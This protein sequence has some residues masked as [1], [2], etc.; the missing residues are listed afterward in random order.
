MFY[1]LPQAQLLNPV[2]RAATTSFSF[3]PVATNTNT[4]WLR[5]PIKLSRKKKKSKKHENTF[6]RSNLII[7]EVT[8]QPP[9]GIPGIKRT[10]TRR[11][12]PL[13]NLE[14]RKLSE[15]GRKAV[16]RENKWAAYNAGKGEHPEPLGLE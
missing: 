15:I 16:D 4:P 9:I 13:S 10:L 11:I 5:K 7:T 1:I 8:Q 2:H 6:M 12:K 14:F 3:R